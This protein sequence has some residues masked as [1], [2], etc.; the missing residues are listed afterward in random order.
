MDICF[1]RIFCFS[2][3]LGFTAPADVFNQLK[4][5]KIFFLTVCWICASWNSQKQ[6]RINM[7]HFFLF[8]PFMHVFMFTCF[9]EWWWKMLWRELTPSLLSWR[10]REQRVVDAAGGRR[11]SEKAP[12][13][14]TD[15]TPRQQMHHYHIPVV[16]MMWGDVDEDIKAQ[17]LLSILGSTKPL[18][19]FTIFVKQQQCHKS[20]MTSKH[21]SYCNQK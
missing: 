4:K 18:F 1:L 11:V 21:N 13:K 17:L 3:W 10:V 8:I 12:E 20:P 7:H 15:L 6:M 16:R 9:P 19:I 14:T 2:N 5:A